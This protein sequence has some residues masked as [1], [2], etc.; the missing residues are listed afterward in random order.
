MGKDRE[1]LGFAV[2][3]RKSLEIL[4]TGLIENKGDVVHNIHKYIYSEFGS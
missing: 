1:S 4:F 2:F 3:T